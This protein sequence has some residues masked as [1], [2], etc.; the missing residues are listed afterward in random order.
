MT[1]ALLGFLFVSS[2]AAAD[3]IA[4]VQKWDDSIS[5]YDAATGASIARMPAGRKPHEFVL[6][7]DRRLAYISNYGADRWT[8]NSPGENTITI[9]DLKARKAAGTIDLGKY[10]RPHGIHRARSGKLYVTADF[11]GA[12]LIVDPA[13]RKVLRAIEIGQELPHM[14]AVTA[15]ETAAF[16]ANSGSESITAIDLKTGT[17][18]AHVKVGGV[19]MGIALSADESKVYVAN[20][21]GN[22]VVVVDARSRRVLSE[23]RIPGQPARLLVLPGGKRMLVA[24][25]DSGEV[26]VI[27]L[28]DEKEVERFSVGD[29]PEGMAVDADNGV[30]YVSAQGDNKVVKFSMPG[31]K[32]LLEIDTPARPDPIAVLNR[33]E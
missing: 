5:L 24:L 31:W 30:L 16:T 20:R 14:V 26:A 11:P 7:P 29:H 6:S 18:V 33:F 15:D 9:V 10:R 19:P 23:I 32:R 17:P 21:P 3:W 4:V 12:L 27:S 13:A 25:I 22:A 28:D 2:L 8:E 1:R